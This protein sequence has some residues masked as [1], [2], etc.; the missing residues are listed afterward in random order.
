MNG[1]V[2]LKMNEAEQELYEALVAI[3][4]TSGFLLLEELP[5][6]LPDQPFVYLG[7]SKELPKPTKSAI[8]GEIELI[9]HVYGVLSERQ[10]ISTIKGTILRQATSNLKRTAHFN[11]GIK[12]QEVKAQMVKDTKQ[13][14]KTI[15]HAVLPLHMQFY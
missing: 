6:D 8:L 4:Q 5:T 15:W 1:K 13:M 10:Q 2:A 3:C 12:H 9:M 14:K 11:W 7:D